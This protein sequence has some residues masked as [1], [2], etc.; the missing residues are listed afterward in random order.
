MYIDVV[1]TMC[2]QVADFKLQEFCKRIISEFLDSKLYGGLRSEKQEEMHKAVLRSI[3]LRN[4]KVRR[5]DLDEEF[6]KEGGPYPNDLTRVLE[7]L[8]KAKFIDREEVRTP[9]KVKEVYYRVHRDRVVLADC[10][11]NMPAVTKVVRV[12][13]SL[14]ITDE[15]DD[16]EKDVRRVMGDLPPGEKELK[17]QLQ[18]YLNRRKTR[19]LLA[20]KKKAKNKKNRQEILKKGGRTQSNVVIRE[21]DFF[22][23]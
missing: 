11:N 7:N 3:I 10:T 1:L 20:R 16:H 14:T 19:I 6:V 23:H 2:V 18:D 21:G 13:D 9:V 5:R 22:R 17:T 12:G 4:V 15:L 8:T